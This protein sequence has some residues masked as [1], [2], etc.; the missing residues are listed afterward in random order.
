MTDIALQPRRTIAS[1][2]AMRASEIINGDRARAHGQIERSFTM[3][4]ASWTAFL[5]VDITVPQVAQGMLLIKVGRQKP[6]AATIADHYIDAAGYSALA[7][8]LA[9]ANVEQGA[10]I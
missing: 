6:G 7:G 3:M 5:G 8:E 4:A 9:G 1:Q 10:D 2:I